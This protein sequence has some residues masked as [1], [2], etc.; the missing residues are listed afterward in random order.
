KPIPDLKLFRDVVSKW[1]VVCLL[2]PIG[3]RRRFLAWGLGTC[4][5]DYN[6]STR[7]ARELPRR[8][9]ARVLP[10]P[11]RSLNVPNFGIGRCSEGR[12]GTTHG[13][14]MEPLVTDIIKL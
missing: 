12:E 4:C 6:I 2:S 13:P 1:P 9:Y 8:V 5:C 14:D 11:S 10:A 7:R 3:A